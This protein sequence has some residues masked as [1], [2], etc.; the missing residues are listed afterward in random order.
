[1][2]SDVRST[3]LVTGAARRIGR[4]LAVDFA[5]RGWNVAIHYRRSH[6]EAEALAA[7]LT[8]IGARAVT[9]AADLAV[10][11]EVA[12]LVARCTG[13]LGPLACLVNNASEFQF[14]TALDMTVEQWDR[15]LAVNLRAPVF[16]AKAL[17]AQLPPGVGG[18]VINIIDQRVWRLTPEYFSY[19]ISKSALWT[20]TRTLAQALAPAVRVNAIAPGPIL[21]NNRQTEEQFAA[22]ASSTPLGHG[23]TSSEIA[24]AVR[25]I[26]DAPAVTGQMIALDGGQ[27]LSWQRDGDSDV[28]RRTA[29]HEDR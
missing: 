8:A 29:R 24:A 26:L 5:A 10:E 22:E 4:S 15:H 3:V 19:T 11:A 20:A 9:F 7:E 23:A 16:L 27:H 13:A 2:A 6:A 25:F 12:T 28:R 21:R 17:A 18:N 14:D 1:M